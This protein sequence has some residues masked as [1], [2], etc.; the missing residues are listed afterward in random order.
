M[1]SSVHSRSW[2]LG[3]GH[4]DCLA[5][6]VPEH[7]INAMCTCR[8]LALP[9]WCL[10]FSTPFCHHPPTPTP[11]TSVTQH[12]SLYQF[13]LSQNEVQIPQILRRAQGLRPLA[14]R[15]HL[16]LLASSSF[17]LLLRL[18]GLHATLF[19]PLLFLLFLCPPS[20]NHMGP[21]FPHP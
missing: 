8:Y 6:S 7:I 15:H 21:H 2:G 13:P 12:K 14:L 18:P 5:V 3:A 19:C 1:N 9:T 4:T 16:P 17:V 11:P 10:P 20:L